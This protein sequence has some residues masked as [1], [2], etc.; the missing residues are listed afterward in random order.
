[1]REPPLNLFNRIT[2]RVILLELLLLVLSALVLAGTIWVVVGQPARLYAA[3]AAEGELLVRALWVGA[4]IALLIV[5][6]VGYVFARNLSRRIERLDEAARRLAAGDLS[7]EIQLDS[8]DEVGALARDM[9]SM[10]QQWNTTLEAIRLEQARNARV[11]ETM[12][13]AVV[14]T[15]RHQAIVSVNAAAEALL[16]QSRAELVGVPWS[17]LFASGDRVEDSGMAFWQLG[18][19]ADDEQPHP[20]VR[21]RFPLQS[22]PQLVLDV[23][24]TPWQLDGH[25]QGYVHILQD[26]SA[27]EEFAKVK[28]EFLLSVAH[29]L[30]GPL[31]SL[32]ASIE[33]LMQEYV[34]FDKRELGAMI[35]L[36]HRS[37]VKFRGLVE[38]LV[39]IGRLRAGRFTVSPG[40]NVLRRLIDDAITQVEPLLQ[41][42]GQELELQIRTPPECIV[43]ADRQRIIQVLI[44]LLTNA[45]KYA[46]EDQPILLTAFCEGNYAFV[47]VADRGPGIA[48]DDQVQLFERF[49][50]VKRAEEEGAGIGLGLAL[51]KGIVEAHGGQIGLQSQVGEGTVFWFSLPLAQSHDH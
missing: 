31:A 17:K 15:D 8:G 9:D 5:V 44:N 38:N 7:T 1:M 36:L 32:H 22:H 2:T 46:P 16:R 43:L 50:R 42:K 40:S 18:A 27:I 21:G 19:A 41:A 10:R 29:E 34:A 30:R 33:M 13:V 37:V 4:G 14:V 28:D 3:N 24:S 11:L 51:A 25:T 39:D 26:A 48:P 35:R 47:Q 20:S 49:Y 6:L 23:V 45:N 12:R